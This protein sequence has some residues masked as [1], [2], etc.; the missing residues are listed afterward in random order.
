MAGSGGVSEEAPG[1]CQ[2]WWQSRAEQLGLVQS[3]GPRSAFLEINLLFENS[4]EEVR[5]NS[6]DYGG[7][8]VGDPSLYVIA[9]FR[10]PSGE[11]TPLA[12]PCSFLQGVLSGPQMWCSYFLHPPWRVL[13]PLG[14]CCT[15]VLV[16]LNPQTQSPSL[17]RC[18]ESLAI[19]ILP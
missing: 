19:S 18:Q 2:V 7:H 5:M 12:S 13:S 11:D 4:L 9:L 14:L 8:S 3:C 15:S 1:K 17:S 16:T 6:Q 10:T